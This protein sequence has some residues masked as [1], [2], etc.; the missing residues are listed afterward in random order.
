M[1]GYNVWGPAIWTLFHTLAEKIK[2]EKFE[3]IKYGLFNQI[4][5]IAFN[6]PCPICSAGAKSYFHVIAKFMSAKVKQK[7]P[8]IS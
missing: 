1:T 7:E 8:E 6:L 2:P 5:L 4:Q 3:K